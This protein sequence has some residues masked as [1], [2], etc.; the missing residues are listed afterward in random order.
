M[1]RGNMA[2]SI[3]ECSYVVR[4][5]ECY[6]V[7]LFVEGVHKRSHHSSLAAN[8]VRTYS[9]F[10]SMK[11]VGLLILPFEWD[12]SSSQGY[13]TPP[14]PGSSTAT[15]RGEWTIR[16]WELKSYLH[17]FFQEGDTTVSLNGETKKI[18]KDDV[19]LIPS[20]AKWVTW[21]FFFFSFAF[22]FLIGPVNL[23]LWVNC[24]FSRYVFLENFFIN[25]VSKIYFFSFWPTG[26]LW[27]DPKAQL[28]WV[29][30][31]TQWLTSKNMLGCSIKEE[32]KRMS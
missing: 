9:S 18:S 21:L 22:L 13:L 24:I 8:P 5:T 32:F 4:V 31:W 27:K 20:G 17:F 23:Y 19:L 30:L 16:S 26:T 15:L 11:Q 14:N 29:L 12:T 7:I 3:G 6:L 2:L 28:V 1:A 25:S 10:H